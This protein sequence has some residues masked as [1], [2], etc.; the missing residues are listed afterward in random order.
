MI[1]TVYYA[2]QWMCEIPGIAGSLT[3]VAQQLAGGVRSLAG[4]CWD[5]TPQPVPSDHSGSKA[6]YHYVPCR[7]VDGD[8]EIPSDLPGELHAVAYYQ[9]GGWCPDMLIF[10]QEGAKAQMREL[11][12]EIEFLVCREP[13]V[14]GVIE[15]TAGS[16]APVATFREAQ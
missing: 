9:G 10:D 6:V 3:E 8:Y 16:D 14:R 11:G 4:D 15:L 13:D 7:R 2:D 1:R 12:G 5:V